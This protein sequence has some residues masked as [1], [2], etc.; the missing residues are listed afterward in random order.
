MGRLHRND[1]YIQRNSRYSPSP[2]SHRNIVSTSK[3]VAIAII[4][5][6]PMYSA[7]ISITRPFFTATMKPLLLEAAT[8]PW[9]G[10]WR[11]GH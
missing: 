7:F 6:I 8:D 9:A 1:A 10:G 4:I 2:P 5:S 3:V 11:R